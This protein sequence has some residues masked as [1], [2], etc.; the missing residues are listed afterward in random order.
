MRIAKTLSDTE[1]L[2]EV[3]WR[4]AQLR[5]AQNL[6]QA[7]LAEKADVAKRTIE[8]L[9]TGSVAPQLAG[10]IRICRALDLIE[11]FELLLP[12]PS[13]SAAE[14]LEPS[15]PG[16][17]R[18]RAS[19]SAN[20][21]EGEGAGEEVLVPMDVPSMERENAGFEREVGKPADVI[22]EATSGA[23]ARGDL[24][25]VAHHLN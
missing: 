6:T 24:V 22:A 20:R 7:Q 1:V 4:L 14:V 10:F 11:R 13:P 23:E 9:E 8:R 21:S 15:I 25:V 12:D 3:G 19:T 18:Q 5:L 2:Q 17:R 16:K